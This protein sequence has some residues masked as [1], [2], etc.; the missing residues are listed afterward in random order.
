MTR[1]EERAQLNALLE[2]LPIF[3]INHYE[4]TKI[5]T[6]LLDGGYRYN[7][8]VLREAADNA[9]SP[10]AYQFPATWLRRRATTLEDLL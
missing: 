10:E 8:T 4:K 5:V 3:G 9:N 6:A 1:K 2:G 7:P